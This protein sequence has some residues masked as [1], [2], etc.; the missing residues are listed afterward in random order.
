MFLK[1]CR[2]KIRLYSLRPDKHCLRKGKRE[3]IKIV[4][5]PLNC[6]VES[7]EV[8]SSIRVRSEKEKTFQTDRLP[9]CY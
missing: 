6:Y 2:Y 9:A 7:S 4:N 8:M 3:T 1:Y 5:E